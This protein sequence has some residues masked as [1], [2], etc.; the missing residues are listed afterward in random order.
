MDDP[1][2]NRIRL[3]PVLSWGVRYEVARWMRLESG[4][5]LP[6]IGEANLLEAQIFGQIT[7]TSWA[8]RRAVDSLK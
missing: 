5:R 1:N 7:F 8:L 6:D 3:K 2:A 4:V